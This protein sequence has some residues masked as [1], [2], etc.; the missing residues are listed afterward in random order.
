[1]STEKHI[2]LE[3]HFFADTFW[4][5]IALSVPETLKK[6]PDQKRHRYI[7]EMVVDWLNSG[8]VRS[9]R[10]DGKWVPGPTYE[11]GHGARG[12]IPGG[13]D[14]ITCKYI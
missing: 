2:R 8:T 13:V 7:T 3:A 14:I 4:K 6:F 12:V 11:R 10:P 9:K 1:M 5:P